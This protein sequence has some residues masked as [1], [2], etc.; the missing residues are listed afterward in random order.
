MAAV[1]GISCHYHDAAA[2]L[3]V[4][5]K[6]VAALQQERLSR[7][8][9][10]PSLPLDAARAV[11][12]CGGIERPDRI[13]Y[14]E[15]PYTKIE[16]ILVH[17][18]RTFPGSARALRHA[19]AG[20]L[21]H[22]LWVLDALADGLAVPRSQVGFVPHHRSHAASAFFTSGWDDAAVLTVDG[23]GEWTTTALWHGRGSALTRLE[24]LDFPHSLGLLYAA[25]TGWLGFEVNGGEYK[26][27]GLAAYG[28][29]VY[30]E[31]FEALIQLA[32]DGSF[33]LDPARFG[34]FNDLQRGFGPGL[35][36]LLGEPRP[37]GRP[38][39]ADASD[40]QRWAD[41]AATLQ[42]VT[43]EAVL[44]LGRRVHEQTGCTR[45]CLAGGVALNAV[46]NARLQAEG[47]FEQVYV[48]PAAG[49]AGA[50]L[51]AALLGA[52][53]LG[54]TPGPFQ[55][56]LGVLP[57]V[58]R[59]RDVAVA[60]GLAVVEHA[61]PAPVIAARL[62]A[63]ELVGL[64]TGP[65]EWGPRALGNR[66]LLADPGSAATREQINRAVKHREPFRPFAP[67]VSS[68]AFSNWFAGE[69]DCMT[70]LMTTVRQVR[71]PDELGAVTHVDGTAR[72][73]S[74]EPSERLLSRVLTHLPVV[75]NTSLNGAGEPI[76]GTGVDALSF[77]VRHGIDALFVEGLEIRKP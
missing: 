57:D 66:S 21:G 15:D 7:V 43:E 12:R 31:A 39:E 28:R 60:L 48:H 77:F 4:D 70:P 72:V 8:K 2:A 51:G 3:V 23:V 35:I 22:K 32:P 63:G 30:R 75:L 58:G 52:I 40:F 62:E 37:P 59:T 50:A 16:R 38:W 76:C 41:V 14:Y 53:E 45:L 69:P 65:C 74:V 46:A 34:G 36:A 18:V 27:M 11:L 17:G 61:E 19:L 67:A 26:V 5:G 33:T 24:G 1:L 44:G 55:P 73:Q 13:V 68:G 64:C 56:F 49:D 47:P 20:Q 6:I 10:D 25:L 71:R 42:Q 29:P 9:D 54:D